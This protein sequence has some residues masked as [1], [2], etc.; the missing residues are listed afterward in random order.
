VASLDDEGYVTQLIE[1]PQDMDNNL[2]VV[3]FYYFK[4]AEASHFGD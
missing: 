3:G 1:K 4:S 2:V